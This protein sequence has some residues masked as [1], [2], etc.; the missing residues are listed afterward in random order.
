MRSSDTIEL[1]A[2]DEHRVTLSPAAAGGY[3]WSFRV[4][5]DA[6]SVSVSE[7][8][9]MEGIDTAERHPAIGESVD[10]EFVVRA[11]R[12]GDATVEFEHR[13]SWETVPA[14]DVYSLRVHV[15]A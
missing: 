15:P 9:P 2:G 3:Q 5:G 8:T 6:A 10:Q 12:P 4:E 1:R 7:E 11:E 14:Q 13:R